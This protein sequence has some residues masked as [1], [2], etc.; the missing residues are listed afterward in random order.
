MPLLVGGMGSGP[1]CESVGKALIVDTY[2]LKFIL[3]ICMSVLSIRLVVLSPLP[4]GRVRHLLL[5]MEPYGGTDPLCVFPVIL[6]E[7]LMFWL[8]DLVELRFVRLSSF[9]AC[10]KQHMSLQF[11]NVRRPSLF[12][13]ADRFSFHQYCLSFKVFERLVSVRLGRII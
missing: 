10:W 8:L 7:L 13:I 4:S 2:Y 6:R 12:P 11:R 5:D 9:S 3:L 1:V